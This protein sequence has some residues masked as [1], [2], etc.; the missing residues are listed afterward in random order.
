LRIL[1]DGEIYRAQVAG[2]INSYFASLIGRLP[3]SYRPTMLV[4]Q[5]CGLSQPVH[6]RLKI[7]SQ[8]ETNRNNSAGPEGFY[9]R[10]NRRYLRTSTDSSRFDLA[11]PTYYQLVTGEDFSSYRCPLV[12]TVWDMIHELFADHMDPDAESKVCVTPLAP[13]FDMEFTEGP[14]IVP[15]RPYF[16]YVGSRSSYK[17]F[18]GLASSFAR[19]ASA[20]PDMTLCVVGAPFNEVELRLVSELKL[21]SHVEN[22][23]YVTNNH[24]T[25]L[26]RHSIALV[27]PSLYEGFGIPPLEAMMCETAVLASNVASI[28]EVVADAGLLFDPRSPDEL[29]NGLLLLFDSPS[30]RE[31]LIARGRERVKMFSWNTTATKTLEI[32][33]SISNCS[34]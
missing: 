22:Y 1:Y 12:L 2:G 6:P 9:S 15:S 17:N 30:E 16:L 34:D 10:L 33:R 18:D 11:H 19:A 31:R 29:I 21:M 20:R 28:P 3:C 4:A 7:R 32:Y 26:Y 8:Q 24:L 5:S 14:E 27:Y 13:D 25:K 23:G